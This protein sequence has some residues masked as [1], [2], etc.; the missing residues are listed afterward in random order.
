MTNL[1]ISLGVRRRPDAGE[2]ASKSQVPSPKQT[3]QALKRD[4]YTCRCCGFESK[5]YQK[6]VS[7]SLL[8]SQSGVKESDFVTVCT[9]CEMT[10]MQ[11]RAGLTGAGYIIWL[12]ELTQAELNHAVRALYIAQKSDDEELKNAAAR[13]L[14]VLTLRRS[15]AKKRLGTDDPLV[16]A[17]AF[18]ELVTPANY[19]ARA[20]KMEGLRFLPFARYIV[21]QNGT[22]KDIFE[23]MLSYWTSFEGPFG[24]LP[25]SGWKKLFDEVLIKA[26]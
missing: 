4:G 16:L 19:Q 24:D 1:S 26:K 2:A 10:M 15:E 8:P 18:H 5:K 7:A 25:V 23:E 3:E 17:T 20:E 22:D 12:P 9:F 11:E 6:V 14:D 21:R 13:T